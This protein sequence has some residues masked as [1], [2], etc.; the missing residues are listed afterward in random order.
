MDW[1]GGGFKGEMGVEELNWQACGLNGA[2]L[3]VST[4]GIWT[5]S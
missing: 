5:L 2:G 4:K 1:W 3:W